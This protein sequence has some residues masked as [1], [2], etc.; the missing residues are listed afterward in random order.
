MTDRGR[1]TKYK[2]EYIEQAGKLCL[3]GATDKQMADFFDVS[4]STLNLWKLEHPNFS[5]SLKENKE[6][7]NSR[8]ERA[9]YEKALGYR[10]KE[11]TS[12]KMGIVEL[13]R[14][15]H[16]DTTAQIFWLKNRQPDKWRDRQEIEAMVKVE[17][18]LDDYSEEELKSLA[19][20]RR[21]HK[22]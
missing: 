2:D 10:Y 7:A 3:L 13:E 17:T 4:E 8:V 15:A 19:E 20:I 5:E 22:S 11:E 6:F 16:P 14:Q 9:L 21:N 1:P 12:T 18:D